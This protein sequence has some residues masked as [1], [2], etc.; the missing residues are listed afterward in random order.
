MGRSIGH[1]RDN[2]YYRH[3]AIFSAPEV[4]KRS[5]NF[6]NAIKITAGAKGT[7]G[8]NGLARQGV[9]IVT[10]KEDGQFEWDENEISYDRSTVIAIDECLVLMRVSVK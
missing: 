10:W 3:P 9:W 2:Y 6:V 7:R 4:I 5:R 1:P 8:N